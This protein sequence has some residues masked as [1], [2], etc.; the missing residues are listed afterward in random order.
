MSRSVTGL[1]ISGSMTPVSAARTAASRAAGSACGMLRFLLVAA[2]ELL[3]HGPELG[4]DE[5][6]RRQVLHGEA[7]GDDLARE[8]LGV[9]EVALGALPV[10]LDLHA[11]AVVL[12][13]LREKDQGRGVRRLQREHEGER[14][15][16]DRDGVESVLLGCER[17]PQHPADR[18]QRQAEE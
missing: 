2:V 18:E 11:V 9:G 15:E 7:Q 13:V 1:R 10:L 16:A 5:L 17:V 6:L 14:R 4:A 8:V 12:A 3:E